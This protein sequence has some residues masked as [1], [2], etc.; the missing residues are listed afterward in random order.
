MIVSLLS[1]LLGCLWFSVWCYIFRELGLIV[2]D[3]G[4]DLVYLLREL[5]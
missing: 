2:L 5:V 1:G 4:V 3:V